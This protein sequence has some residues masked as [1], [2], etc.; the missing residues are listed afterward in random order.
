MHNFALK[1]PQTAHYASLLKNTRMT[2]E[3]ACST[4][5]VYVL[6]AEW[7]DKQESEGGFSNLIQQNLW[8]HLDHKGQVQVIY[9]TS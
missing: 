3:L 7:H 6:N 8:T 4:L 2:S 9:F 1:C 5:S